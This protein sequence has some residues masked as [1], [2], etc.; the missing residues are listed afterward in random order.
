MRLLF[1]RGGDETEAAPG[2]PGLGGAPASRDAGAARAVRPDQKSGFFQ[3]S[4]S[5]QVRS[6]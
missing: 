2:Q 5:H 4:T 6:A 1:S 3:S